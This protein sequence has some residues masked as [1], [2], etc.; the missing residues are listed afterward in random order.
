MGSR[1]ATVRLLPHV[2]HGT[3]CRL[4]EPHSGWP[5]AVRVHTA[6]LMP[7]RAHGAWRIRREQCSQRGVPA[8]AVVRLQPAL[9]LGATG[10]G[11]QVGA[12]RIGDVVQVEQRNERPALRPGACRLDPVERCLVDPGSLLDIL[13]AQLGASAQPAQLGSKTPEPDRRWF[14]PAVTKARRPSQRVTELPGLLGRESAAERVFAVSGPARTVQ[15]P[16]QIFSSSGSSRG[17]QPRLGIGHS[18]AVS[19][20]RGDRGGCRSRSVTAVGTLRRVS[21]CLHHVQ[22]LY[23]GM[24]ADGF[25]GGEPALGSAEIIRRRAGLIR[26]G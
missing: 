9:M 5:P 25:A 16:H 15:A 7:Q 21:S 23:H 6:R 8:A 13:P 14:R 24:G 11:Q 22:A 18:L 20:L 2:L 26:V 19:A 1:A 12:L 17:D 3:R 4:Q 10:D